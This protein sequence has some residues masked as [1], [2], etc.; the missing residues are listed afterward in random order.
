M[1]RTRLHLHKASFGNLMIEPTWSPEEGLFLFTLEF[2]FWTAVIF[3][4]AI[5]ILTLLG[6]EEFWEALGVGVIFAGGAALIGGLIWLF[7]AISLAGALVVVGVVVLAVLMGLMRRQE[8]KIFQRK[9]TRRELLDAVTRN[10]VFS[11]EGIDDSANPIPADH[12]FSE[13]EIAQ[14]ALK[15]WRC[16]LPRQ[17]N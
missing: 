5:V 7:M 4:G 16:T 1:D 10:R 3:V 9:R 15:K 11:A 12:D 2:W 8:L 13:E 14:N 17:V 6:S